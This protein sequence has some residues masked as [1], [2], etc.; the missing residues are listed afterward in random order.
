MIERNVM[1]DPRSPVAHFTGTGST[2]P[3]LLGKFDEE[4]PKFIFD[5]CKR[6]TQ[7]KFIQMWADEKDLIGI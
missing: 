4:L 2:T 7:Q 5:R 1:W 6:T 3:G